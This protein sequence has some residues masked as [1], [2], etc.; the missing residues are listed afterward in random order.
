MATTIY[1]DDSAIRMLVARGSKVQKWATMPLEPGL[2][3][4]GLISDEDAVATKVRELK[5]A[6][7]IGGRKVIAG[8]SGINCLHR[9]LTLPELPKEL[10]PEAV[11]R[12]AAR[13]LGVPLEQLYLSWQ[14][15]ASGKGETLIYLAAIPR[16]SADALVSTLRKA[17]LNPY[18]MDLRPLALAR[19]VT[20]SRAILVDL[21]PGSLDLVV[22]VEGI[23]QVVRSLPLPRDSSQEEKIPAMVEELDRAI[24]FYNSGHNGRPIEDTVPL[25][26]SGE[27]AGQGDARRLLADRTGRAVR[28]LAP[29][30]E[31]GRDFP[32]NDYSTNIGLAL[33]ELHA[34]KGLA[35]SLINLNAL[36][37]VY[38][39]KTRPMSEFLFVPAMIVGIVLVVLGVSITLPK[40]D[41]T[42][43]LRD[44][45]AV[46]N[47]RATS[48]LARTNELRSAIAPL[49]E[50][51]PSVGA[52]I[53]SFRATFDGIVAGRA[54]LNADL[55]QVNNHLPAAV[56]LESVTHD[57]KTLVIKGLAGDE[58]AIFD[59]AEDLRATDRF[60]LVV[61]SEMNQQEHLM[62]FTLTLNK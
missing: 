57:G 34:D 26:V 13:L 39:P 12:E 38:I 58:D 31:W 30:L 53:D 59:Y 62:A 21:Q 28:P 55:S 3:H 29:P 22:M 36:P 49:Q 46:M 48:Q 15:L 16:N 14:T 24:T 35:Y 17:G 6:Q 2:V 11:K 37:E 33:K 32:V 42:A 51:L 18:L 9:L 1:I 45:L 40:F 52:A 56:E 8:I 47:Q 10:L 7:H 5:R 27:L 23:P 54:E 20:D 19:T 43:A 50:R 25:L 41:Y 44:E 4:G 61:I 60:A